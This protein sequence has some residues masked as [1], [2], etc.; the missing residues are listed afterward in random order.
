MPLDP[1]ALQVGSQLA[2][3]LAGIFLP[4]AAVSGLGAVLAAVNE[5]NASK[6]G[7]LN[8]VPSQEELQ[9]FIDERRSRRIETPGE[10]PQGAP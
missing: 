7:D 6:S 10:R 4:G 1:K 3:G 5:Y 2:V 9:A 8:Y